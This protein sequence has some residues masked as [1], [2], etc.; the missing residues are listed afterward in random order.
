MVV[1]CALPAAKWMANKDPGGDLRTISALKSVLSTVTCQKFVLV[2]TIDVYSPPDS[3]LDE[4]AALGV[5]PDD[6][7]VHMHAYGKHRQ[8]FEDFVRTTWSESYRIVRLPALFGAHLRKNYIYDLLHDNNVTSINR[9]SSFQ[10]Y[11]ISLLWGDVQTV[12]ASTVR[13]V[14]LFPEPISS[15]VLIS[16]MADS[17]AL[18]HEG[19]LSAG[20]RGSSLT[21]N[22]CTKHANLFGGTSGLY[23]MP[24]SMV[25]DAFQSFLCETRLLTRTAVSCIAW[26]AHDDI[27]ALEC[28]SL[29]GIRYVEI[30]PAKYFDWGDLQ[31]AYLSGSMGEMVAELKAQL[32][33]SSLT[34]S[35]I[36]AVLYKKPHLLVFGDDGVRAELSAHMHMIVDFATALKDD[37]SRREEPIPIVFGSPRNRHRPE[38]VSAEEADNLFLDLFVPIAT[39]AHERGCVVCIEPNAPEYGCNFITTSA[40]AQVLIEKAN[41]PGLRLHLDTGCMAMVGEDI[42][43]AFAR[44][45][46]IVAHVHVS[47]PFLAD[48]LRPVVDHA[49][50]A[51]ALQAA[52]YSKL[53]SLELLCTSLP[54]LRHS[55]RFFQNVYRAFV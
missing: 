53:L 37:A 2:S 6:V 47:E 8:M 36:Q 27:G 7:H 12:L 39:Y 9:N 44:C 54:D 5:T 34:V 49:E 42:G 1:C 14:N 4:D 18:S 40:Q 11:D 22:I 19:A 35:S 15:D 25:C 30:A 50:V 43:E 23:R 29:Q 31:R 20:H 21:Y 52:R 51:R 26:D 45:A 32:K 38:H 24:A 46:D 28:L 33:L 3:A 10:W 16:I 17:G 55:I 13:E 48:F 41:H